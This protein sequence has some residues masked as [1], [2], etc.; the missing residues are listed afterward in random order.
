MISE[1]AGFTSGF[2]TGILV[3]LGV[4]ISGILHTSMGI[5]AD[6]LN[7]RMLVVTRCLVIVFSM[8]FFGKA[9]SFNALLF[10][11][12]LYR[13]SVDNILFGIMLDYYFQK[14]IKNFLNS[15]YPGI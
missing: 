9:E 4:L 12:L 10:S 13:S 6:K 2:S 3:T 15:F 5:I 14:L 8:V 7:K 11:S 1:Q